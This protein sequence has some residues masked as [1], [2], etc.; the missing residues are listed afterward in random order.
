MEMVRSVFNGDA[1]KSLRGCFKTGK[2]SLARSV[3]QSVA[4][5]SPWLLAAPTVFSF[6]NSQLQVM[7]CA[8]E[9]SEG[10][11]VLASA[12]FVWLGVTFLHT[13]YRLLIGKLAFTRKLF[14]LEFKTDYL[15]TSK[16]LVFAINTFLVACLFPL[17]GSLF[18]RE[19][20]GGNV[21]GTPLPRRLV[22]WGMLVFY[23]A[24]LLRVCYYLMDSPFRSGRERNKKEDINLYRPLHWLSLAHYVV[25]ALVL[26]LLLCHLIALMTSSRC[27]LVINSEDV[28]QQPYMEFIRPAEKVAISA[29]ATTSDTPPA[30]LQ[31]LCI[32]TCLGSLSNATLTAEDGLGWTPL[33]TSKRGNGRTTVEEFLQ[34][35]IFAGSNLLDP[36]VK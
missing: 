9:Q 21:F 14:G 26:Y 27:G 23:G 4:L 3:C 10:R 18:V 32:N 28:F 1:S 16:V 34:E 31:D 19:G 12:V 2:V 25:M 8:L 33:N 24:A 22:F 20:A 29:A 13:I 5:S 36:S 6:I 35:P 11:E 17:V 7:I 15:L 30:A